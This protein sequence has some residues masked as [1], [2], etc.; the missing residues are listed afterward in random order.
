[1]RP[2]SNQNADPG[3]ITLYYKIFRY[4]IDASR[5]Q[6]YHQLMARADAI[7]RQHIDYALH[8]APSSD[9]PGLWIEIQIFPSEQAYRDAAGDLYRDPELDALYEQF[10]TLLDPFRSSIEEETYGKKVG[11]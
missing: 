9:E 6:A 7:Y 1:M 10:L 3:G 4:Y 8:Y 5:T 2:I 11:R